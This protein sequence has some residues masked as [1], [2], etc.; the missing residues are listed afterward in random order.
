[1]IKS[2]VIDGTGGSIKNGYYYVYVV[3]TVDQSEIISITLHKTLAN[4]LRGADKFIFKPT[5]QA[6]TTTYKFELTVRAIP[7][8]S[9]NL[10]RG[11]QNTLRFDRTSYVP[12]VE[13]WRPDEFWS[14]PFSRTINDK[15]SSNMTLLY[16]SRSYTNMT[17]TA[18]ISGSTDAKF[19]INNVLLGG[20]YSVTMTTVGAAYRQ[21]DVIRLLGSSLAGANTTNDCVITVTAVERVYAN[22]QLGDTTNGTGT[23]ARFNI[24]SNGSSYTAIVSP[25]YYGSGYQVNDLVYMDGSRFDG[26]TPAN[27]LVI[28]ITGISGSNGRVDTCTVTGTPINNGPIK[29][30]TAT[31][32]AIDANLASFQGAVLPI[33][34]VVNVD[35]N[36]VVGLNYEPTT[37][38][39]GQIQGTR[40]YF[41]TVVAPFTYDDTSSN[42]AKIEIY[43][44]KF[45]PNIPT[46]QYTIKILD[47]GSKYSNGDTIIIP[48]SSLGGITGRNDAI[49][50]IQ[51]VN[52]LNGIQYVNVTGTSVGLYSLYYLKPII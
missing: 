1:M 52:D 14:S 29:T 45:D 37:L 39:P 42:G 28:R 10:I 36:A 40:I 31:G 25:F 33:T 38:K 9:N 15:S 2:T 23:N 41:Y 7:I 51:Y 20:N 11:V 3:A 6:I 50:S 26:T 8:T 34:Q 49:I 13:V 47:P 27:N 46:N 4:S 12:K 5:F 44:P 16:Y 22:P 43:R 24:T 48:G 17:A 35:N 19:T 30:F 21:N 18:S 32:I